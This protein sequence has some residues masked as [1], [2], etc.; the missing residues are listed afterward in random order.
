VTRAPYTRRD[1]GRTS[2]TNRSTRRR[3]RNK[4][5]EI[6]LMLAF[7]VI[8]IVFVLPWVGAYLAE[9][10]AHQIQAN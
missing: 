10:Y 9:S 1:M 4:T 7:L 8:L 6:V 3:A 2:R 5:L